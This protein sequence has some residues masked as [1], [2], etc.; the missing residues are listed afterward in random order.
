MDSRWGTVIANSTLEGSQY[1][2]QNKSGGVIKGINLKLTGSTDGSGKIIYE[3]SQNAASITLDYNKT[4]TKPV[5]KLYQYQGTVDG[6]SD[7]SQE[8]QDLLNEAGTTGGVVYLPGGMYRL[9]SPLTVPAGV[10][11]RGAA[12][13]PTREARSITKGTVLLAHYGDGE[14]FLAD[15][16]ALITLRQNAGVNGIRILYPDNG[17][18]D[19]NLSTTYAIR[20]TGSGVYVVNT[21]IAA[22]AYGVDFSG[23][24]DHYIKKL[25]TCCYYNAMK[26]G[27]NNGTVEGCLQNG[28]VLIRMST[29]LTELCNNMIEEAKSFALLFNPIT[30]IHCT[31]II[32]DQGQNQKIYNTFAYGPKTFLCNQ[33]GETVNAVNVGADNISQ[34]MFYQTDGSMSVL[35]AMRYNGRSYNLLKGS[36]NL[37]ARLSINNKN[38]ATEEVSK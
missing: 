23:C 17:P 19:S 10:E 24:D 11:L 15:S 31:Y 6:K 35:C 16:Q 7:L 27:G 20:G 18:K 32:V 28:T 30:R 9:D 2:I 26:V 29:T 13:S 14:S 21:S 25:V 5:A 22:A 12:G 1:S 37:Y 33:G 34:P 3:D 36:L 4:Y 8:I 38:E